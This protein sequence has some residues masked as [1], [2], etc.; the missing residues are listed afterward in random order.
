M[1]GR[2]HVEFALFFGDYFM[3]EQ[4]IVKLELS[5]LERQYVKRSLEV[6]RTTLVRSR[7]KELAGSDV[8]T[9]RG[10]EIEALTALIGRVSV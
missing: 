7:A 1:Y 4:S 5:V 8:Y 2:S 6:L 9:F 10:K 3:A